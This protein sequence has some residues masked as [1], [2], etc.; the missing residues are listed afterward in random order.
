MRSLNNNPVLVRHVRLRR[1]PELIIALALGLVATA[2]HPPASAAA[3]APAPEQEYQQALRSARAGN[4]AQALETL[5]TLVERYPDNRRYLYDYIAVLGWAERDREALD[6]AANL[7][8]KDAPPYVLEALGRSARNEREYPLAIR[9]YRTAVERDPRDTAARIGLALSLADDGDGEQARQTLDPIVAARPRDPD[10]VGALAYVQQAQGLPF[11][12]LSTYDRMLEIDPANREARRGRILT[13]YR[14]GAPHL[15]AALA[16]ES[17][18]LLSP[19]ERDAIERDRQAYTI[20][21]SRLPATAETTPQRESFKAILD[22]RRELEFLEAGGQGETPHARQV[23]HDLLVSLHERRRDREAI[24]LYEQ[25]IADDPEIPTYVLTTAGDTYLAL[26]QPEQARDLFLRALEREPGDFTTRLSLF[27]A[28]VDSEDFA[29]AL[30]LID[31]IAASE[32]VWLGTAPDRRPNS[33]KLRA[34]IAAAYARAFA[35]DLPEAERRLAPLADQAPLNAELHTALATVQRWRGWPRAALGEYEIALNGKPENLPDARAGR[36][37]ALLD[38]GDYPAA[39]A[40]LND[41]RATAPDSS[42]TASLA[43]AWELR[44]MRELRLEAARTRSSGAQEGSD[45]LGFDGWLYGA[46]I[47]YHY[48][49]FLHHH[50]EQ[51]EFPEGDASYRRI[52]AGVEYSAREIAA[53]AELDRDAGD[54]VNAGLAVNGRWS[55]TDTWSFTAGADSWSD[56]IPLRG[57]LNEDI[58]GWSA[59]LGADWRAHERRS[60]HVGLQRIDFSDDNLRTAANAR[61]AQRL[62]TRPH[63]R[64]DGLL[65]IYTSRNTREGAPYFNPASDVSVDVTLNNE[66]LLYRRYEYSFRHR[67]A[68]S[69]GNYHQEDFG[70]DGV[71]AAQYEQRWSPL[72]RFDLAYGLIRAR[73]VYDGIPEYQ[74]TLYLN[75]DWRF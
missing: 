3:A 38:L 10:V 4:H 45:D 67:L 8:L 73:R 14:I 51:A 70:S 65:G 41:L 17:P 49:P 54:S 62:M 7:D 21:W 15:A 6:H 58:D 71:W 22:L 43:R 48:R 33:A 23:R 52:G 68:L 34:D 61:L 60:A 12:A 24:E 46:P 55:P 74:T 44:N 64:M 63:Y 26:R 37:H 30:P 69:A 35:D 42:A 66:W 75:L 27:Y 2:W 1:S 47:G 20:R 53:T 39:E 5:G 59:D 16:D 56:E 57:R 9:I 25:H 29:H 18:G 50:F 11:Q 32:P 40:A 28:Y 13:A 19:D 36:G 31:E 72:D